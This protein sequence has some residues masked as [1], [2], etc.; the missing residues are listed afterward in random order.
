M[1][2][3]TSSFRVLNHYFPEQFPS[4]WEKFDAA[5]E[6]RLLLIADGTSLLDLDGYAVNVDAAAVHDCLVR[7][8]ARA[9]GRS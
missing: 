4:F 1:V 8:L 7:G 2:F 9:A 3:D 6:A 5:G